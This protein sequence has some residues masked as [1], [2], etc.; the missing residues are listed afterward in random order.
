MKEL[1]Y[2]AKLLERSA[3]IHRVILIAI[4]IAA[5]PFAASAGPKEDAQAVFDK[6][7]ASFTAANEDEVVALFAPDALF[8][9]T[10]SKTL[11]TTPE[12]VQQYF[13]VIRNKSA[14][15]QVAT[16]LSTSAQVISDNAVFISG[17]WQVEIP[18]QDRKVPLRVS[19][20]VSKRGDR[21]QIVQFHNSRVP[22]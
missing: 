8:W 1:H 14:G 10:G 7:L 17:M 13:A 16:S 15:E 22:E 4:C 3:V 9:G 2:Y 19:L 18:A 6:F 5:L 20:L 21:W 12:G 11:V